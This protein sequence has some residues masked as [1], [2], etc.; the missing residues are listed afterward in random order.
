MLG[1]LVD[2]AM[3]SELPDNCD[4]TVAVLMSSRSRWCNIGWRKSTR[5]RLYHKD[6][7]DVADAFDQSVQATRM[8]V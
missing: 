7:H 8:Q 1:N 2:V 6:G 3:S 5:R 4:R